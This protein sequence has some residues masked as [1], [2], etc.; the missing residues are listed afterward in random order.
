MMNMEITKK[1]INEITYK[2]IGACIEVHKIVGPGLYEEVYHKCLEREF[3]ILG[4][5]YQSELMI[6]LLYKERNIDCKVICDFLVEDAIVL[7]IKSVEEFHKIHK[8]QTINYMN[9]LQVPKSILINFNVYNLYHEG[10]ETF[11]SK[12]FETLPS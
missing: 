4:L 2:I 5:K 10:T 9:L 6:P 3:D 7:E 1:Y 12:H 11:V 8:A